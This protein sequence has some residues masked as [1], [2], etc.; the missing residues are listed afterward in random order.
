MRSPI[1]EGE[2]FSKIGTPLI[3]RV[4]PSLF[5]SIPYVPQMH[6]CPLSPPAGFPG[7]R[8]SRKLLCKRCG[9]G[10]G[11]RD[12]H[13]AVPHHGGCGGSDTAPSGWG[14]AG[15]GQGGRASPAP[16]RREP[17]DGLHLR[18]ERCRGC[19][20]HQPRLPRGRAVHVRLQPGGTAQGPAAGLAVG[21]LRGQRGVRL[22]LRQGVCGRPRAGEE[23][24]QG[25]GGAGPRAHEPAEQRGRPK[26][27]RT[28]SPALR[29][30]GPPP[31][32]PHTP[33]GQTWPPSPGLW[34]PPPTGTPGLGTPPLHRA[35]PWVFLGCAVVAGP[36]R[37]WV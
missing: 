14:L 31:P 18:S 25:V 12:C 19:E 21:R 4:R 10:R 23:L 7:S 6:Q 2:K 30:A 9:G 28:P 11:C 13:R 1:C 27:K 20:R 5:P 16:V 33:G 8:W 15:S 29:V 24:C 32:P 22:P 3:P 35:R 36:G 17:G 37:G 26:G 34:T